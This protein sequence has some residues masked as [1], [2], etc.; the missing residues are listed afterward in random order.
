MPTTNNKRRD[1][2]VENQL[3][4][5]PPPAASQRYHKKPKHHHDGDK[6]DSDSDADWDCSDN[7]SRHKKPRAK[8]TTTTTTKASSSKGKRQKKGSHAKQGSAASPARPIY[9]DT[10]ELPCLTE[11]QQQAA[12]QEIQLDQDKHLQIL[13]W[14]LD[15]NYVLEHQFK[16]VRA[17]AG[18]AE[19]FPGPILKLKKKEGQTR[20]DALFHWVVDDVLRKVPPPSRD[21]EGVLVDRGLLMADVVGLGKTVQSVCACILRNA[22][23]LS[24]DR[25]KK[26][27]LI[28]SPNDAVLT[29]WLETLLKAGVHPRKIYRLQ[30]KKSRPLK[31][32]CFVLCNRYDLQVEM[33]FLFDHTRK[34]KARAVS[35]LFPHAPKNL[36]LMLK[37]Q[38]LAEK[39]KATNEYIEK[40]DRITMADCITD[41]LGQ[42][43]H[44][45]APIFETVVIDEA[46][47]LKSLKTYWGM[48]AGLLGL[49]AGRMIPMSGTPFNNN[50]GDLSTLMTFIDPG[51]VP[52]PIR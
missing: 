18:V 50:V 25:P 48:A 15:S 26:P 10:P 16:G 1:P 43:M 49:H 32:D 34:N 40:G 31:G 19:D 8:A 35:P 52:T 29:Q 21:E 17:L 11:D 14:Q 28:V 12:L 45:I 3:P 47:F 41:Y 24:Q 27:T 33:R 39:G 6:E 7:D 2:D 42:H 20:D 37:N 51:Y 5:L 22:I 23:A 4:N 13:L 38:Y 44:S 36:L 30:S 9:S 46:H